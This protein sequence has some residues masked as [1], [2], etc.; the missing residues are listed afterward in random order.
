MLSA[1]DFTVLDKNIFQSNDIMPFTIVRGIPPELLSPA[2]SLFWK[3]FSR[4][5]RFTLGSEEK[6]IRFF[7]RCVVSEQ[8]ICVIDSAGQLAGFAALKSDGHSFVNPTLA[9]FRDEYGM[10]GGVIRALIMSQLDSKP[11]ANDIMIESICV[12]ESVRGMGIGQMLLSYIKDLACKQ[13]KNVILDVIADNTGARRLYERI[14]FYEIGR[15]SFIF[16]APL[17]GFRHA[18]RMKFNTCIAE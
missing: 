11:T 2:L 6:A 8:A 1:E 10:L 14:G 12:N 15:K 7:E 3:A 16:S 13:G 4:K 17:F 18:I 5:L 9:T